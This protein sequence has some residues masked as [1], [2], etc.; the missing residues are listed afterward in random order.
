M[1]DG[2]AA[3]HGVRTGPVSVLDDLDG[4]GDEVGVLVAE[5]LNPSHTPLIIEAD[6]VAV[7][8]GSMSCH[9]AKV[10]REFEKPCVVQVP[11]ITSVATGWEHASV[12][13]DEGVVEAAD[14]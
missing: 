4:H 8:R 5:A 14:A 3:S 11:G 9:A 12:D 1:V 13:G 6:A 7:E 10:C 2:I